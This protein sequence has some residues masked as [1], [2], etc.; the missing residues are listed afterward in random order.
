MYQRH[1]WDKAY[2]INPDKHTRKIYSSDTFND[3]F[4]FSL[5]DNPPPAGYSNSL[6]NIP[7]IEDSDIFQYF[8]VKCD[9]TE[10]TAVKHRD[11]GWNFIKSGKVRYAEFKTDIDDTTLLIRGDVEASFD[12]GVVTG[13]V[14]KKYPVHIVC[15]KNCGTICGARCLCKAGL[16]GFCKHVAAVLFH[17]MDHQ[18][19][20]ESVISR[21]T[22]S[23]SALQTWHQPRVQGQACIKFSNINFESFNYERDNDLTVKKQKLNYQEFSSCPD[24]ENCVTKD[25]IEKFAIQL[26]LLGVASHF[27]D[28]LKSNDFKPSH[29]AVENEQSEN[30]GNQDANIT[31]SVPLNAAAPNVDFPVDLSIDVSNLSDDEIHFYE[32]R[33]KITT[34]NE[35]KQIADS[36]IGQ[37]SNENWHRERK[38]R[39]TASRFKEVAC[40]KKFPCDKL[41]ERLTTKH[42]FKTS[43]TEWGKQA[44]PIALAQYKTLKEQEGYTIF[45]RDLGLIVNPNFPYLAASPDWFVELRKPGSENQCGL[46]EVTS[47]SK[48]SHLTPVEAAEFSAFYSVVNGQLEID[49]SHAYFYQIQGQMAVCGID[50]CDL[51]VWTPKGTAVQRIRRDS[52]FWSEVFPSLKT[53]YFRYILPELNNQNEI[54]LLEQHKCS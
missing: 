53:F 35:Q 51:V 17:V 28:I 39:I 5:L 43:H 14:K 42:N 16:G 29:S 8:L 52:E 36:T 27:V 20:G 37:A 19:R 44:E 50:W 15:N 23:T 41:V 13:K 49:T 26:S 22:A 31:E 12:R 45:G 11:K 2:L 10:S 24:G 9:G 7:I 18:R 48:Y 33:V 1:G 46:V 6:T 38:I 40:R 30:S 3:P 54:A 47:L 25:K 4:I 34:I 32:T 21:S